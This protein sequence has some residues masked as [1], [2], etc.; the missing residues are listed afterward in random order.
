[1]RRLFS[2]AT[3]IAMTMAAVLLLSGCSDN[4]NEEKTQAAPPVRPVAMQTISGTALGSMSFNGVVRSAERAELAFRVPGKLVEMNVDEGDKVQ[5]GQV[6]AKLEQEE[7]LTA[8]DSAKV[9]FNKDQADYRRGDQI[10]KSSQAISKSD[11]ETLKTTRDLAKNKLSNARQ[12]LDNSSLRAPFN[13]VIAKKTVSNFRNVNAGQSI[14]VLH[15]LSDLEIIV[16]VPGKLFLMPGDQQK[17]FAMV[18]NSS[19]VRLPVVYKNFSADA[20]SLSQTYRVTLALTDLKGQ[21]VLPGMNVRIYPVDDGGKETIVRIPLQA[22]SPTNTGDEFV[23]LVGD[24]GEVKKR[25]IQVGKLLDDQVIIK[26]GLA[27]GDRIVV[28]GVG[29]LQDG[30]C[31]EI[32]RL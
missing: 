11:L 19:D 9:R 22:V 20:D 25:V 32:C 30:S 8:V 1:M 28:A 26:E 31:Q 5:A 24:D 12:D 21:N 10:F 6:L 4:Q 2:T 13:G 3:S 16:D 17:A 14:Y 15:D 7:F 27:V 18:E 23:W 29:A